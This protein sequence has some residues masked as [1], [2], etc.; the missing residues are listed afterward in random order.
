MKKILSLSFM[1]CAC[2]FLSAQTDSLFK[3]RTVRFQGQI[4]INAT[5]FIKQF[6]VLNNSTQSQL[7][8]FDVNGKFLV[9]LKYTPSLLIGPRV[10][11][12]Y[13]TN[14]NY[15]NNEQQNNERS[16][17][18]NSRS[19]RIGLELQQRISKRWTIYYGIDYI[20]NKSSAS[21][22]TTTS[23]T[24]GF[25][26]VTT[27]TRTQIA[28][29]SKSTGG[30]PI[31]GFQF[32]LNRWVCLGT[33][34]SFYYTQTISGQKISSSNPNNTVPETFADARTTQIILPFFI[35]CNI[36]F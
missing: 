36:V 3:G 15:S 26:A 25:P 18:N 31:L 21:T 10:G 34:T 14:H 6:I 35:N 2:L 30:G 20:N 19:L 16:T 11:F 4:G 12:G 29:A 7:S 32:H 9:G 24:T 8:P 27:T 5:N 13:S 28:S 1:L 17:D 22:I 23:S 33:E